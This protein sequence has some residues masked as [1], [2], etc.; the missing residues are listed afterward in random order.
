MH[1]KLTSTSIGKTDL[2]IM[3]NKDAVADAVMN[4]EYSSYTVYCI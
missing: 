3:N 2:T 1:R 4:S